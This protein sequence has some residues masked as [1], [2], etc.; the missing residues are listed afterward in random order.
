MQEVLHQCDQ[1]CQTDEKPSLEAI[2]QACNAVAA[3]EAAAE[4]MAECSAPS[5]EPAE[6]LPPLPEVEE[7]EEQENTGQ[8]TEQSESQDKQSSTGATS[9]SSPLEKQAASVAR[10]RVREPDH[11][12][13]DDAP[14]VEESSTS[15]GRGRGR[16]R[17][18]GRG[19][20]RPSGGGRGRGRPPK[21]ITAEEPASDM[22]IDVA[23]PSN[24]GQLASSAD[25]PD[26]SHEG[27]DD[28]PLNAAKIRKS[29]RKRVPSKKLRE[30]SAS[31]AELEVE[32]GKDADDEVVEG[33]E[34]QGEVA[35]MA[36][37]EAA[38]MT[39][40][41]EAIM[42]MIEGVDGAETHL[43]ARTLDGKLRP[44]CSICGK[45][46]SEVSSLRR[47]MRIHKGLKPYECVLCNRTF[48]QGNQLK[49]HMRIHTGEMLLTCGFKTYGLVYIYQ[50]YL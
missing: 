31:V 38:M 26:F 22:P 23:E 10:K 7:S 28:D 21:K 12:P 41:G 25:E 40:G 50:I 14:V 42:M 48:R 24:E 18:S 35:M 29:G 8:N 5:P 47:H 33:E 11:K 9:E 36:E 30:S 32:I 17:Q 4:A 13:S 6:S 37:G 3:A 15:R 16:G 45:C 49:T 19:R 27:E 39:E 43:R 1:L 46:F 34:E 2:I 20:G 44:I